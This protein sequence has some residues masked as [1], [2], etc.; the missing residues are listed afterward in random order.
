MKPKPAFHI[1]QAVTR[2]AFEDCFHVTQPAMEGL[3]VCELSLEGSKE[4]KFW[5]RVT[6]IGENGKNWVQASERFFV[7][8]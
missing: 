4:Y 5:W 6:A 7:A 3:Q 1:G 2:P 8:A